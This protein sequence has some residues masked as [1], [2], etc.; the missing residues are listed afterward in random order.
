MKSS[1]AIVVDTNCY[2]AQR[3]CRFC[4]S[5]TPIGDGVYITNTNRTVSPHWFFDSRSLL[6]RIEWR[7][8]VQR[9][10]ARSRVSGWFDCL[11][12]GGMLRQ[13]ARN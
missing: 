6:P 13:A 3:P 2:L 12:Q 8:A 5:L 7:L 1:G 4:A 10:S 9:R 11:S